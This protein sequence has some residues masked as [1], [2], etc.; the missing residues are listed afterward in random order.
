MNQYSIDFL[1][2]EYGIPEDVINLVNEAQEEL[3]DKFK[4]YDEIAEYNQMKIL[5]V[6]HDNHVSESHFAWANGYG[7][8]DQGRDLVGKVY[9]DIFKAES[10]IVGPFVCDGTH[11]LACTYLG[12]LRSG[13]EMIY[14]TGKPYDTMET[15]IGLKGTSKGT[16]FEYGVGFKQVDLLP[17]SNN[18]DIE[19]VKAAIGPKTKM[20]IIQRSLGYSYRHAFSI[21]EI[22]EWVKACK[23]VKPDVICMVDNCYGEFLDFEDP[24]EAGVDI[25]A[26]SLM[27][28]PGG[29]ITMGGGYIAGR[30]DL[31]EMV[32]YRV[33]APGLGT[34][35]GLMYDQTRRILQG[36]FCA[37]RT[38]NG[39]IKGATLVAKVFEKLGYEVSPKADDPRNDIVTAIKMNSRE[40]LIEFCKAVQSSSAVGAHYAPEP[41]KPAGYSDEVIMASGSFIQGSTMEVSA[42]A[43]LREPYIV[44]YQGGLS[45]EHIKF[46]CMN[47]VSTLRKKNLL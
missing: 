26:G 1:K 20:V 38:V 41:G 9:A 30:A 11:A 47:V 17:G 46:V 7:H 25:M 3:T 24:I 32:S 19:G 2:K 40:Q 6:F 35:S 10:C 14:C 18:I 28:N 34:D 43:P 31:V 45:F 22:R 27:K 33:I 4:A 37:P 39:A 15:I 42:D 16:L 36:I 23:S 13:D 12:I 29:G 21:E 8:D 44:Y 5:K